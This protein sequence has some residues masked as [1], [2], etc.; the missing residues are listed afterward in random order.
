MENTYHPGG[1]LKF[2]NPFE[3]EEIV[4]LD[5]RDLKIDNGDK[6]T[7]D[8]L[9]YYS[10]ITQGSLAAIKAIKLCR[11][12]FGECTPVANP[13]RQSIVNEADIA[14]IE[15]EDD[16]FINEWQNIFA[17]NNQQTDCSQND[18]EIQKTDNYNIFSYKY[19]SLNT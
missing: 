19:Q 11:N 10:R 8:Y 13:I 12:K 17:L 1:T 5:N 9:E 15:E 14:D 6:K 2:K 18:D 7:L 3:E 16:D 4:E